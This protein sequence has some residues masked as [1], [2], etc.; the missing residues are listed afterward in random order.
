M[1]DGI[2][3]GVAG[4]EMEVYAGAA[5]IAGG[6]VMVSCCREMADDKCGIRCSNRASNSRKTKL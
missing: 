5:G 2:A 1:R 3:A 4:A 6:D